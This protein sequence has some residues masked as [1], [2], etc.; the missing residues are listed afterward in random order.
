MGVA[1]WKEENVQRDV[2]DFFTLYVGFFL[3]SGWNCN[4]KI[5]S[6]K[7]G[8]AAS[9]YWHYRLHHSRRLPTHH[10]LATVQC[11]EMSRYSIICRTLDLEQFHERF[12]FYQILCL[13]FFSFCLSIGS[14]HQTSTNRIKNKYQLIDLELLPIKVHKIY[15][16]LQNDTIHR[17]RILYNNLIS[18]PDDTISP[19]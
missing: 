13:F 18:S 1:D 5:V 3:S 17:I 11:Q 16:F 15:E 7:P 8:A 14:I 6:I 12:H 2:C 19:I 4:D 9:I 10:L